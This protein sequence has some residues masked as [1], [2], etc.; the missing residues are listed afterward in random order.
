MLS[1]FKPLS[2]GL[3]TDDKCT[4]LMGFRAV[5]HMQMNPSS[6]AVKTRSLCLKLARLMQL[7]GPVWALS[8]ADTIL[9]SR[10]K[11]ISPK[12][13]PSIKSASW[14]VLEMLTRRNSMHV[15]SLSSTTSNS[16]LMQVPCLVQRLTNPY[17]VSARELGVEGLNDRS[18]TGEGPKMQLA[19]S[20]SCFQLK[21][22]RQYF[23]PIKPQTA[24][25]SPSLRC[26]ENL[27]KMMPCVEELTSFDLSFMPVRLQI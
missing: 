20:R 4:L 13:V 18:N 8:T 3:N 2:M 10:H 21:I 5:D 12:L 23:S 14:I 11:K 16:Q 25:C 27:S 19:R 15:N 6:P 24:K 17:P 7:M 22:S 26:R 1:C 9:P